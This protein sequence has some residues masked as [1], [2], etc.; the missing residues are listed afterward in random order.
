MF[1]LGRALQKHVFFLGNNRIKEESLTYSVFISSD[2]GRAVL[3]FIQLWKM[4]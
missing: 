1:F 3:I 4:S 2:K